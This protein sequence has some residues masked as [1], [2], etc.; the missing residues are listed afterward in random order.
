VVMPTRH[1]MISHDLPT[2][3]SYVLA[4]T[5]ALRGFLRRQGS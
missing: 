5:P 3:S 2:V 4:A 1:F